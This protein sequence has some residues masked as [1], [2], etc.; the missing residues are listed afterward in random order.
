MDR[1]AASNM[2]N[3]RAQVLAT[4]MP[5]T[6]GEIL[7]G[8]RMGTDFNPSPLCTRLRQ[9]RPVRKRGAFRGGGTTF[10]GSARSRVFESST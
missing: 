6:L 4:I 8:S 1:W 10:S 2:S 5:S 9:D 3:R 7:D